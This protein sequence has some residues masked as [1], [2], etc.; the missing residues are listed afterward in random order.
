M[1]T[2]AWPVVTTDPSVSGAGAQAQHCLRNSRQDDRGPSLGILVCPI[3]GMGDQHQR[4]KPD[5]HICPLATARSEGSVSRARPVVL[6][7][8][9]LEQQPKWICTSHPSLAH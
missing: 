5:P 4:Q 2:I 8:R 7:H 3:P 6:L 1:G 9:R